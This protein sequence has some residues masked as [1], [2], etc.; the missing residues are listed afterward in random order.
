[1]EPVAALDGAPAPE[2]AAGLVE[3]VPGDGAALA[4]EGVLPE[5]L[6]VEA[7]LDG[8]E[9][10]VIEE[11]GDEDKDSDDPDDKKKGKKKGKKKAAVEI[12]FDEDL[13]MFITRKKRKPGRAKDEMFGLLDDE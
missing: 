11:E 1:V 2:G 5:P 10:G 4:A 6:E 8:A 12:T 7:V 13:G 3:P 9:V